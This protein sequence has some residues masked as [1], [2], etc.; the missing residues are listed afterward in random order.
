MG[1]SSVHE[2]ILAPKQTCFTIDA[3]GEQIYKLPPK[4]TYKDNVTR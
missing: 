3:D 4:L 2:L 1:G